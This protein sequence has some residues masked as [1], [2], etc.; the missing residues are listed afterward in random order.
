MMFGA[1]Q[2]PTNGCSSLVWSKRSMAQSPVATGTHWPA[3]EMK[4]IAAISVGGTSASHSF[5]LW[6][7]FLLHLLLLSASTAF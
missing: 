2:E 5:H 3:R 7:L 4:I 6:D 1:S